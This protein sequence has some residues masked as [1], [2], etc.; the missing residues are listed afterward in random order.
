MVA[1]LPGTSLMPCAPSSKQM[2]LSSC[3]F[4]LVTRCMAT[5]PSKDCFCLRTFCGPLSPKESLDGWLL[6]FIDA[7]HDIDS[8]QLVADPQATT[9]LPSSALLTNVL[10][11]SGKRS[12]LMPPALSNSSAFK[13]LSSISFSNSATSVSYFM[14][15]ESWGL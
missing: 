7:V 5:S 15:S 3:P 8:Q 9:Q 1:G 6:V 2:L 11:S 14:L 4:L 13:F 12:S 10:Q